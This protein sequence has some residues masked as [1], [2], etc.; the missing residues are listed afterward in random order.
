[1][2]KHNISDCHIAATRKDGY[3]LSLE[4]INSR[5]V[6]EWMCVRQHIFLMTYNSVNQGHWCPY[7]VGVAH[8]S[9]ED[10]HRLAGEQD[11]YFLSPKYINS[12]TVYSWGCHEGHVFQSKYTRIQQGFWCQECKRNIPFYEEKCHRLAAEQDGYFLSEEYINSATRYLWGCKNGHRWM[13][14]YN[15]VDQGYWCKQ[16]PLGTFQRQV[17]SL[18]EDFIG[19]KAITGFKELEWFIDKRPLEMDF[20]FPDIKFGGECDGRQHFE[21]IEYFG[22][23]E[24]FEYTR[25]HD[26]LKDKLISEHPEDVKYFIR[27]SYKE[28]ITKEYI[29]Y[30]LI[31]A[32]IPIFYLINGMNTWK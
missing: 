4:Y 24:K 20:W 21:P 7:C 25:A 28:P 30:K 27:L 31:D 15:N 12:Y 18:V 22:G 32:G 19:K 6:Y 23:L 16:C 10:C 29:L 11:G 1:M 17:T 26:K 13:A 14:T 5:T 8:L 2:H 3:F 9:E